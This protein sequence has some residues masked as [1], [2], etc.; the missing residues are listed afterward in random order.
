MKCDDFLVEI[1]TE[2]LPPKSLLKLG[3]AFLQQ[4]TERLQKANL[5]FKS[6]DFYATPRRLAVE[7]HALA[8]GQPD[9]IVERRGPALNAAYDK[10]GKPTPACAGFA[11]SCG[12]TADELKTIKNAQGEWVGFTQK[13]AGKKVVELLPEIVVQALKA[14]PVAKRMRWGASEVEFVRPVQG[15]L[16]MYGSKVVKANILGCEASKSTFGHRF[17][18]P[19][20]ITLTDIASYAS[21]LKQEGYVLASFSERREKIRAEAVACV[22]KAL[23]DKF[24]SD[25]SDVLLDEVTGLVEWPVALCGNFDKEFLNLPDE[26]LI[27]SMQDH[28]RYFPVRDHQGK[29]QASFVTMSNIKSNNPKSVIH[30]NERVLR[31]RLSDAAFFYHEDK[32]ESLE[33][34][35]ERL[36][37]IVYQANLGSVFD[38]AERLSALAK[39]IAEKVGANT[40]QAARAG[41]LAKAD[42]TTS[43]VGEFPELQ[44]VMGNY[45]AQHDKESQY[46]ALA[47]QE[48][49]MPR[50]AG[51]KLPE[52]KL[53]QVLSLADKIDML[54]GAFGIN[55]IPTGDKDPFGLRR[56]AIGVLRILVEEKIDL[57]LKDVFARAVDCFNGKLKNAGAVTQLLEFMQERMRSWCLEQGIGAGVF[58]SV[59]IL[60]IT[61]PLDMYQ[62][63]K[64]VQAFA[65]MSEA[66]TLSVANKRVSNIL[67]KYPD[68]LDMKTV[69]PVFFEHEVEKELARQLDEK[70]AI[71]DKLSAAGQYNEVLLQL[72]ELRQPIDDFFDKVMVMTDDKDRRENRILMLSKLRSLFLQVADI[73]LLQ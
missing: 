50:F 62:R 73:A 58:A 53:G 7:V 15:V 57:D 12:I 60:Q 34:R 69:N 65:M 47:I 30:G 56:A 2:E 48:Q 20:K 41:Y 23:G 25:M 40:E 28:Q 32:K 31:A 13:M 39:Y 72:A 35:V 21:Q 45:Y 49:Y 33:K 38:R 42:L 1:Q 36:R 66:E 70:S 27:S 52:S 3:E 26:V 67:A 63:I 9:Q 6:A 55:Q 5:D 11:K 64:A 8:A 51:D 18:A 68:V 4:I 24:M 16:M 71:V 19:E 37:G 10:D 61:N 59:A 29:L 14:L 17:M 54:V 46:V 43:M 44:G 22:K